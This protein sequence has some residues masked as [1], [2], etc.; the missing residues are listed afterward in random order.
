MSR[1]GGWVCSCGFDNFAFRGTCRSCGGGKPEGGESGG[2]PMDM[3]PSDGE[4]VM[5]GGG[6]GGGGGGGPTPR[7]GDW[8]CDCG[9]NNFAFRIVCNSCRAARPSSL[10][11]ATGPGFGTS[12]QAK[13]GDWVCDCGFHNFAFRNCCN[14]CSKAR[15]AG[16]GVDLDGGEGGEH[17]E[18]SHHGGHHGHG[19]GPPMGGGG[20][21]SKPGDWVCSCGF[22]NFAFRTFCNSCN[23][24][25]PGGG[26]GGY[27]GAPSYGAPPSYGGG[28]SG[29]GGGGGGRSGDWECS[30]CGYSNFGFRATCNSCNAAKEG[31]GSVGAGGYSGG[32]GG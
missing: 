13:P 21:F 22:N 18:H 17:R 2:A 7:P 1:P 20:G 25:K 30:Q 32:G 23:S 11:P 26:G 29:Y 12:V 4:G 31:G 24:P 3:G 19:G 28:G 27:G 6:S 16:A 5:M 14:S 10:P 9:F 15:P 8:V